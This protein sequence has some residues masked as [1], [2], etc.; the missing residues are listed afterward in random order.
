MY[1]PSQPGYASV[2]DLDIPG[3]TITVEA[4]F[5][6]T[7]PYTHILYAGDLVSKHSEWRDVNYLLRPS[8]AEITTTT[9]YYITPDVCQID[10]NRVYHVAMVYDG[11]SLK[12]YRN[13]FLL[14]EIAATGNLVQNNW[15]TRIG[16]YEA[17]VYPENL[18]GYVNEV[19][20][21][22]VARTQQQIRDNMSSSL[23]NPTTQPGLLAYYQFDNL[24]NKQGN[25]AWNGVL[26]GSATIGHSLPNCQFIPDNCPQSLPDT[27][28]VNSYTEVN[29]FESC[30]NRLDV[31]GRERI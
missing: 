13:G 10:L 30:T 14:S 4:M 11:T 12:F 29:S 17:A 16:F 5:V 22:N 28:V 7:M 1:I 18:L 19:R 9:G 2:G 8:T 31:G 20:I 15:Q 24:L 21:W 25:P 23:S 26:G 27:I 3:N 6:R